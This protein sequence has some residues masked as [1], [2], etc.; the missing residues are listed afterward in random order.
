MFPGNAHRAS[1]PRRLVLAGFAVLAALLV[2][3]GPAH[4]RGPECQAD[5]LA[6]ARSDPQ[7]PQLQQ[8]VD[9]YLRER[10]AAEHISGVSLYVSRAADAPAVAVAAGRTSFGEGGGPIC[11]GTLFQIGSITK[12]FTA[13]LLLKLE[14]E[15]VLDIRDTLDE[16][17]PEYPDWASITIERLLNMTAP[18]ANY[19][20]VPAWQREIAADLRRLRRPHELVAFVYPGTELPPPPWFYSNTNYVLAEMIVARATGLPY[21]EAL[22]TMLL[23]PLGLRQTYYRPRT[24]PRRV[25]EAMASGYFFQSDCPDYDP[26]CDTPPL[27]PLSGE[28]MKEMNLSAFGGAGGI[29]ASLPDVARWVRALFGDALP[30]RQKAELFSLVSTT[31]ARP[32][33]AVKEADRAGFSLGV[34]QFW[35]PALAEPVWAY[36]G[37]TLGFRVE[38]FRRPG[39][40]LVVAIALNSSAQEDKLDELYLT[41][42][43]ILEPG[44]VVDPAAP[45]PETDITPTQTL[46]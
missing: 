2:G 19:T 25:L 36:K 4:S 27:A 18:I 28:D 17:L 15:G 41:V 31:T 14:A 39:D 29:V 22:R 8:A 43:G 24:S 35:V 12:S 33:A 37:G 6:A 20:E 3:A 11:P 44:A 40:D 16:W 13:V 32:I 30:P 34:V 46:D 1:I 45:P 23:E 9:A 42:L 21:A 5:E 10:G 7:Y 26:Q 38:W